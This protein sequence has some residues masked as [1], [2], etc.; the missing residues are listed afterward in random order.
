MSL[1]KPW[2]N[3]ETNLEMV[4]TE[5]NEV[6]IRICYVVGLFFSREE[7]VHSFMKDP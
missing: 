5:L 7:K 3:L 2:M 1:E 6:K 4:E